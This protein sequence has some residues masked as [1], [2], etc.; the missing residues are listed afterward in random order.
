[1]AGS[2]SNLH[3]IQIF[4]FFWVSLLFNFRSEL[5]FSSWTKSFLLFCIFCGLWQFVCVIIWPIPCIYVCLINNNH[6]KN[7]LD[8]EINMVF[9]SKI[10]FYFFYFDDTRK[11]DGNIVWGSQNAMR[12]GQLS[13]EMNKYS[14]EKDWRIV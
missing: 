5:I 4:I 13:R 2:K 7:E 8:R 1:M 12:I 14:M 10:L 9:R 3:K 6:R 11:W